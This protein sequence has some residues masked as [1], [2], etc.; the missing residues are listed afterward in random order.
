[1]EVVDSKEVAQLVVGSLS[2]FA[3]FDQLKD[4]VAK[5]VGSGDPPSLKNLKRQHSKVLQPKLPDT[6]EQFRAADVA[7]LFRCTITSQVL[8]SEPQCGKQKLVGQRMISPG[9]GLV[10]DGGHW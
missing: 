10:S 1:V 5:V 4:N 2:H 7:C 9:R 6:V 8:L 3:R